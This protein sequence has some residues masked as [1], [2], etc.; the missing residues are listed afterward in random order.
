[1][2]LED[3]ICS[4]CKAY[5]FQ[6]GNPKGYRWACCQK[7]RFWFPDSEDLPGDRRGCEEWEG[8]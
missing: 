2:S 1:M 5:G 3:R 4:T 8:R 7:K 6:T